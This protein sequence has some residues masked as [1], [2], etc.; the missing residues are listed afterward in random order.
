MLRRKDIY[1]A[2]PEACYL[3]K[4]GD[5][6]TLGDL[7]EYQGKD[8][9]VTGFNVARGCVYIALDNELLTVPAEDIDLTWE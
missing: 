6:V 9:A 2:D 3:E 1:R 7:V 8:W 4:R 5:G